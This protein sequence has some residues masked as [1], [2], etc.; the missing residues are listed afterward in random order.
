MRGPANPRAVSSESGC[1][2]R[3]ACQRAGEPRASAQRCAD[4]RERAKALVCRHLFGETS[5]LLRLGRFELVRSL[6][7]G[8][9]GVVYEAVNSASAE[10]VAL[11]RLHERG[12]SQLYRLKREFRALAELQHR[13]LVALHELWVEGDDA[14]F[15]MELVD[16]RDFVS[17]LRAGLRAGE[18]LRELAPLRAAFLQLC[19]GVH[20][21]HAAGKLHRDLKP[22]NILVAADGRVVLLDFGLAIDA[23]SGAIAS[24]SAAQIEGTPA[25]MAPEQRGGA[26]CEASDWFAIG[27]VLREALY[28]VRGGQTDRT[29]ARGELA[30]FERL[31]ERLS[32]TAATERP[33][34]IELI[35][36]ATEQRAAPPRPSG[37]RPAPPFVGRE[38][39]LAQLTAAFVQSRRQPVVLIVRGESGIGKSAL[40]RE[41][42]RVTL[43]PASAR[44]L[45]GRCYER[46]ALPYKAIDVAI[47]ELSRMLIELD[48]QALARLAPPE[49]AALLQLFPVLER[50]PVL[51][52]SAAALSGDGPVLRVLGFGALKRLLCLLA[53]QR[54]LVLCIDDLQWSDADSGQLLAALLSDE[55]APRLLLLAT[56]R[57]GLEFASP[58]VEALQRAPELGSVQ[59][60]ELALGALCEPDARRL[61][62]AL[63][64]FATPSQAA[65]LAAEARGNPLLLCEL[66]RWAQTHPDAF[67]APVLRASDVVI[68]ARMHALSPAGRAVL[69]LLAVAGC[70]LSL[71][72]IAHAAGLTAMP[73]V[74]LREL[75]SA[76][77]AHA[78]QRRHEQLYEVDHDLIGEAVLRQHGDAARIALHERL[79][80]AFEATQPD[81]C[82]ALV[83][84]YIGARMPLEA[85]RC[86]RRAA[87]RA[88]AGLAFASAARLYR[89]ALELGD[90]SCA[91]QAALLRDYAIALEQAG[92]ALEAAAAYERA[93]ELE[94]DPLAIAQLQQAAAQHC[95][96]NGAYA[97]GEALLRAGYRGLGLYW[98]KGRVALV[99][100]SAWLH[101]P[102]K[103]HVWRRAATSEALGRARVEFLS[104]AGRGI[105]QYD[106]LRAVH[107]TL[108]CIANS[109]AL[110][111]PVWHA[112]ARG[113]RGLLRCCGLGWG[114]MKRGLGDLETACHSARALGDL[115]AQADLE[116]QH[117]LGLYIAGAPRL[118]LAA[119]ER[120]EACLRAQPRALTDLYPVLALI[121]CALLDLGR[122]REAARRWLAASHVA[123]SHGD[124]MTSTAVHAHP[125]R[126]VTL[127][128]QE[129]REQVSAILAR[130]LQLRAEHPR[131]AG[132]AW[133]HAT[134]SV[135][136]ALY[137]GDA[138]QLDALLRCEQSA[139]FE[140]GY[141][142]LTAASRLLRARARL[143]VAAGLRAGTEQRAQLPAALCDASRRGPR[144]AVERGKVQLIGAGAAAIRGQT[145]RALRELDRARRSF[146]AAEAKL[147]LA[148]V[149]H[150]RGTLIGG[151]AGRA[152]RE[153]ASATLRAEGVLHP[154]RWVRWTVAGFDRVLEGGR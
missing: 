93:A 75:K 89:C 103:L 94:S 88:F 120:S 54:P 67:A 31:V 130:Q 69:E 99:L 124:L 116:G 14:Y 133:T 39:E 38:P 80:R 15:T 151:D 17:H 107:N 51:R 132:L 33:G 11:K 119:A 100:A 148:S 13:N 52:A 91:E 55:D 35:A 123:R 78:L 10:R 108:L 66:S 146:A 36:A 150:C 106:V 144:G 143:R 30:S 48:D 96:R 121:S 6:G 73:D 19:E 85:A 77:L 7:S 87:A 126:Y 61:A 131:Y 127:F 70:P 134:Y 21:L 142:P 64:D 56:E 29:T 139:L 43:E 18:P 84:Q 97:R 149:D 98:P 101:V 83:E 136:R 2:T 90:H 141:P 1:A 37:P 42:A 50:V 111:D 118:A 112:R 34:Y 129:E 104:G 102:R 128:A 92:R 117:G 46:E 22:Q 53:E 122:L 60:A 72:V 79:A 114:G 65:Q 25:Y 49:A 76:R 57:A 12:P 140:S 81:A 137:W 28:G 58:T 82:E 26:A 154:E 16:G 71:G 47:D 3:L 59:F 105:E 24:A 145:A 5:D 40:L 62:R 125:A 41:F 68:E 138:P 152:L 135:E 113:V 45:H 44:I 23:P 9:M 86:A 8:G 109:E 153:G 20:A 110:P 4:T 147:A 115:S 63:C 27:L 74:E 32:A 95:M